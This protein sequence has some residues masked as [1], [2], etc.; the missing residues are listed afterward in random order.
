[1]EEHVRHRGPPVRVTR[2]G[3][4]QE[5][6]PVAPSRLLMGSVGNHNNTIGEHLVRRMILPREGSPSRLFASPT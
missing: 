1:M 2:E 3:D 4:E 5:P 6:K